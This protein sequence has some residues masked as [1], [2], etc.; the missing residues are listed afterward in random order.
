MKIALARRALN[1]AEN[2]LADHGLPAYIVDELLHRCLNDFED[3][4]EPSGKFNNVLEQCRCALRLQ[5]Y[6]ELVSG[7]TLLRM[8][9][10]PRATYGELNC[11]VRFS[12]GDL[13]T[14]TFVKGPNGVHLNG[15]I[16]PHPADDATVTLH[17]E[18]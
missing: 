10:M 2:R 11:G 13:T 14:V 18:C 16:Y 12:L 5:D 9:M 1:L 8:M 6:A 3:A 7:I 15:R 4:V 17:G